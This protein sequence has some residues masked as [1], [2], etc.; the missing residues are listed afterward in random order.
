MPSRELLQ[1]PA[2]DIPVGFRESDGLL[3]PI[4][5]SRKRVTW[6]AAKCRRIDLA[7]KWLKKN[8]I[9]F[10]FRCAT[11][12]TPLRVMTNQSGPTRCRVWRCHC[13]DRYLTRT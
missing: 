1:K 7:V 5:S 6:P 10:A 2:A 8:K 4:D 13:T 11:C 3:V 12:E 9:Q